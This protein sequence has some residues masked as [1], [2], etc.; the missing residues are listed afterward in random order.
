MKQ[1]Q[2]LRAGRSS[3]ASGRE[4]DID[5]TVAASEDGTAIFNGHVPAKTDKRL[6]CDVCKA[7]Q[8]TLKCQGCGVHLCSPATSR[9]CMTV[10]MAQG[11]AGTATGISKRKRS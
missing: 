11:V 2:E 4:L 3:R 8:T 9:Q 10:H 5:D 6:L 7:A 1:M